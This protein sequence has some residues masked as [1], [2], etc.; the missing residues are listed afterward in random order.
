MDTI[1]MHPFENMSTSTTGVLG[2]GAF[3]VLLR[4]VSGVSTA[5]VFVREMQSTGGLN[6]LKNRPTRVD[7]LCSSKSSSSKL[8]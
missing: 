7:S 6:T 5:E 3:V 8:A 2:H 4:A 1:L